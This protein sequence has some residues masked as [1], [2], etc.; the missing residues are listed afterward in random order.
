M[1]NDPREYIGCKGDSCLHCDFCRTIDGTGQCEMVR[2]VIAAQVSASHKARASHNMT[3]AEFNWRQDA[4]I[5]PCVPTISV[6]AIG[7][8]I[9]I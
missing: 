2:K 8:W 9:A 4:A 1:T 5:F 7:A 6:G 3:A